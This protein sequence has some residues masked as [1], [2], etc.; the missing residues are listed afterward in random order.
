VLIEAKIVEVSVISLKS[1]ASAGR[2]MEAKSLPADD[3]DN[4]ILAHVKGEYVKQFGS[5]LAPLAARAELRVVWPTH[6]I[7]AFLTAP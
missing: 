1:S 5:M 3:S 6:S 4:A 2:L 7:Q